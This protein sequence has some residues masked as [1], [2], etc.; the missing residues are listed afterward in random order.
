MT[1]LI[2]GLALFL[3]AHAFIR[4]QPLRAAVVG[5]FGAMRYRALFSL[6]SLAGFAALIIGY[7]QARAAGPV[8][9]WTPPD[10]APMLAAVLMASA[11]VLLAIAYAPG[12]LK[13]AIPHPMLL[14]VMLW[15]LA[16]LIANG[17]LASALLFGGFLAWALYA[18]ILIGFTP[19]ARAPWGLGDAVA[20]VGGLGAWAAM[21]MWL[22]PLLIGV[23][24]M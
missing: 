23:A 18:R 9:L 16:H 24:V 5:R 19:S 1:L 2:L 13:A 15:A 14:A 20:V 4:A 7:G 3:G 11:F 6:V 10:Y 8:S 12:R 22:H 17:D 21:A